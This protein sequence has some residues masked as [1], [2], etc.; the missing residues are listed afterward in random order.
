ML[1]IPEAGAE[2]N[3]QNDNFLTVNAI[4]K[5]LFKPFK[6]MEIFGD[7]VKIVLPA[8]AVLLA[9]Y[10]T[11]KTFLQKE[12]DKNLIDI[13][14]KNTQIILPIRLQAYERMCLF[15]ERIS[16]GNLL[17][18]VNGNGSFNAG[19]LHQ[20]LLSEIREEYNH[21]L[22]QQLYMSDTAWLAIQSAMEDVVV[23][24]NH[25]ATQVPADARS[26]ELGRAVFEVLS[27]NNIDP[28]GQALRTVKDEMRQIF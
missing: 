20:I 16:P 11:V 21:N 28:V 22:S 12:L 17:V 13:R 4:T 15:L 14:T 8:G 23:N 2:R 7:F 27:Q 1:N 18:R 26:V 10:L 25:A 6:D 19:D 9:M 5:L 3:A 24:I